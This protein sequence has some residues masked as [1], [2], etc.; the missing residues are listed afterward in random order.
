MSD[1]HSRH[2]VSRF[3]VVGCTNFVVSF[4]VFYLSFHYL[5]VQ[6]IA[7][8]L[9]STA[10][11]GEIHVGGA[12]ANVLA[13]LAGMINSFVLNRTWTFGASGDTAGQAL[14]FAAVNAVTLSISTLTMFRFVDT[15]GYPS[16]LVWIPLTLVIMVLNYLGCRH[17]AFARPVLTPSR[18]G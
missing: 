1:T 6:R 11:G 18:L 4:A 17:W 15:L 8:A 3:A 2:V 14:R 9:H 16:L 12:V 10:G 13:Y 7:A 5:P